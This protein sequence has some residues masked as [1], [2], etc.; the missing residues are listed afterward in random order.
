MGWFVDF[1]CPYCRYEEAG[2]GVGHG[3]SEFPYLALF[4]CDNCKSVGST[5]IRE[6][7]SPRCGACYQENVRLLADDVHSIDCPK[8][9]E[10][11]F[12]ARRE[13]QWN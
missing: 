5:W 12:F 9:G 11:A 2:I 4:C 13:G 6:S 10:P 8:C 3:K 7:E 1:R